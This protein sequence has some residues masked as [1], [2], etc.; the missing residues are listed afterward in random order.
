M[1]AGKQQLVYTNNQDI[2]LTGNPQITFFKA[3]FKRHTNFAIESID[4]S[5]IGDPNYGKRF[6]VILSRQGDLLHQIY[7]VIDTKGTSTLGN[8]STFINW[9]NNTAHTLIESVSFSIGETIIDQHDGV[10]LD[11]QSE[12]NDP[13]HEDWPLLNKHAAKNGYLQS[14]TEFVQNKLFIPLQFWFCKNPGMALPLISIDSNIQI[15]VDFK[16]RDFR[17][18]VNCDGTTSSITEVPPNI[19]V[20][21]DFIYLDDDEKRMFQESDQEY[22]IEQVQQLGGVGKFTPFRNNID[23]HEFNHPLKN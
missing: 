11:I 22:L 17:S 2:H 16:L 13:T 3:V 4:Q 21:A 9:V 23:I 7:L 8:N 14:K 5:V 18:L 1:P 15:K 10:W 6:Q 19:N 20:F 12:L